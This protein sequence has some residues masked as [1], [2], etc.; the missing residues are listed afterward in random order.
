[1]PPKRDAVEGWAKQWKADNLD[2]E[3]RTLINQASFDLYHGPCQED[4]FPGFVTACRK[5]RLALADLPR[6]LFVDDDSGCVTDSEPTEDDGGNWR[7]LD[8]G[9]VIGVIVGKELRDYVR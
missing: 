7:S 2:D 5:I 1:M 9:D 8:A 6:V 3:T 4:G